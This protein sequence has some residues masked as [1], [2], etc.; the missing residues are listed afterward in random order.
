MTNACPASI[1]LMKRSCSPGSLRPHAAAEA[2]RG[3]VGELDRV[4]D[5][6]NLEQQRHRAEHLLAI[7]RRRLAES[8]AS[9]RRRVEVAR[10]FDALAPGQQLR[11]GGDRVAAPASRRRSRT[12]RVASGPTST[13]SFMGSPTLSAPIAATKRSPE[14][15]VDRF[16]H[17]EALGGDARLAV[18]DLRACTGGRRRVLEFGADGITMNGSLPPS[19]STVFFSLRPA[20]AATCAPA[21]SLPVSVTA[22]TRRRR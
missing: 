3:I 12:S 21:G 9:T 22:A 10:A 18:V 15:G 16:V 6:A 13:S 20:A 4:V 8:S 17:D 11:A 14:L 1:S 7:R 19:S 5:V 2:E